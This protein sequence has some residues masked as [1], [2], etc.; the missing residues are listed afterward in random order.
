[1]SKIEDWEKYFEK[2]GYGEYKII[3]RDKYDNLK[4][5]SGTIW[6][7]FNVFLGFLVVIGILGFLGYNVY[8]FEN[9]R[10]DKFIPVT[11]INVT[12]GD[13]QNSYSFSTPISPTINVNNY[14]NKTDYTTLIVDGGE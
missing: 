1:M 4:K 12:G 13:T 7:I 5:N 9:G 3:K 14:E 10:Y 8:N 6:K 2:E 11:S